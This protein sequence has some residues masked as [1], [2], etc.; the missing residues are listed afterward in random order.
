[1]CANLALHRKSAIRLVNG[2]LASNHRPRLPTNLIYSKKTIWL[3]TELWKL[4]EY[5][6]GI[7]LKA[8]VPL[9]LPFLQERFPIDPVTERQL[10]AIA[11]RTIDRRLRD[12]K[13]RLKARRY[14]TTKPGR[15]LRS[16]VPIRTASA[17]ISQ[18]GSLELDTVAHGGC[19]LTG[20]FAYTVNAVD[21]ASTWVER[22]AVLGRGERGVQRAI[23]EIRQ[24]LPFPLRDVDFDNGNEF[25]N[26]H[27]IKYCATR[28]IGY[29][30]SR[31]YHKNDQA[32]IEQKNSTHVRRIFG[33]G[34]L[35]TPRVVALMNDLYTHEL[36]LYHN[37]F[38]PSQKLLSKK[39]VGTKVLRTLD[40]PRT[41]CQRLLR[42]QAVPARTKQQLGRQLTT[43]HPFALKQVIDR[44]VARIF[45][46][47]GCP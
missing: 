41:P 23:E 29:T 47:Q 32:H 18:P 28:G 17:G 21:I 36:R 27:V 12:Q 19:S 7:I 3:L 43:L 38:K 30:R 15:L 11:P 20:Q 9:W 6:C 44:K 39:F 46:E 16:V 37:F 26:W 10:L 22:Q 4:T 42:S 45:Q 34:R 24:A 35:D 14:G 33:R 2:A 31:P 40:V 25:L 13:Q 1:M 5:P 8:S